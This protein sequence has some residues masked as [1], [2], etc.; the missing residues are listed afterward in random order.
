MNLSQSFGYSV[1]GGQSSYG[2]GRLGAFSI[3]NTAYSWSNGATTPT[4]TNLAANT[5]TVTVSNFTG[6]QSTGSY[7]VTSPT[8]LVANITET[9]NSGSLPND[10][11]ICSG[12]SALLTASVSGGTVGMGYT[13]LWTGG[14]T[15]NS[16][17]VNASGIY[18]VTVTDAN[19]CQ[20]V[21][22][23]ITIT[24]NPLPTPVITGNLTLTCA[25]PTT[26][27]STTGGGTYAWSNSETGSSITNV[28]V[29]TYTVTVTDANG[30]VGTSPSVATQYYP[31]TIVGGGNYTSIQAAINAAST[32]NV[33]EVC[34]GTYSE[35]VLVNKEVTVK[36]T[37][38]TKPIINFTGTVTGKPTLF[39][40]TANNV[41]I[42]NLQFDVDLSKLRSAI[43]AS[44]AGL[45]AITVKDNMI[46]AYGSPAGSYGDRNAVSINYTGTTNYR[47]ASGGVN[48]VSF[49]GNTVTGTGPS[50]YFRSGISLDE[51]G[52]T[53]T[54]NTLTTINHDVLLRFASNG[55]NNISNNN[56]NG[57]GLE[58]ADQNAGSGTI[59]VSGNTFT[60]V[61]AP[62]TAKLRVKNGEFNIAH[63]I[64]TNIFNTFDWGVSLENMRNVTLDGNTFNGD[65]ATDRHVVVNTKS[66][67]SNS[68]TITQV[69]VTAVITSN[70]FNGQGVALTFQNHDSDNDSYGTFTIG[71]AGNAKILLQLH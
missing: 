17:S 27:L 16:L 41:T 31:V 7:T 44:S 9:D 48:A 43:I 26:T 35:Q 13:Y 51:G 67:S 53:A 46:S 4:I 64:S 68:N 62:G 60:G 39:D 69:P 45:D 38:A 56:L 19:G 61:G 71:S 12:S 24:V 50:S 11:I 6:C 29:G 10:N 65:A 57:G 15:G 52:L 3:P 42:E 2:S 37:G 14:S 25:S 66:L 58:L 47:V 21:A 22:G 34:S 1:A 36:G 18:S 55:A 54:G 63:V 59:T 33:I 49:T 28:G 32:G 8:E 40:V 5:Y 70:N 30:C 23:P 20:K